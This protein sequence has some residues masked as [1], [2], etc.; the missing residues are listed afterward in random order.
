MKVI[1]QIKEG[2]DYLFDKLKKNKIFS[3]IK[4][5]GKEITA[6]FSE[7]DLENKYHLPSCLFEFFYVGLEFFIDVSTEKKDDKIICDHHGRVLR[8]KTE[9]FEP[10][11]F[12][13][14]VVDAFNSRSFVIIDY[15]NGHLTI[16][17]FLFTHQF[18]SYIQMKEKVVW[19]GSLENLPV[20]YG[21]FG[22]LIKNKIGGIKC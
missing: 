12:K 21:R 14:K 8:L 9:C 2:N 1:L 13:F 10:K 5:E 22:E 18:S 19:E 17:G 16:K 15:K 7:P 4:K 11:S 20:Q 6:C 3:A